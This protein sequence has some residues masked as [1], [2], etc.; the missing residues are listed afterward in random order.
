MI[1]AVA[2]LSQA[3][4]LQLVVS[5]VVVSGL[6]QRVVAK[7]TQ[8][9]YARLLCVLP[10]AVGHFCIP[11]LFNP[12]TEFLVLGLLFLLQGW[13]ATFKVG[14]LLCANAHRVWLPKHC[15]VHQ[16]SVQVLLQQ[17]LPV[18]VLGHVLSELA[19]SLL[20]VTGRAVTGP[21]AVSYPQPLQCI[22]PRHWAC[23][24]LGWASAEGP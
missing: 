16:A 3:Q 21:V 6:L 10:L 13:L 12:V 18:H 8:P 5:Y 9:G 22:S 2:G 23:R 19:A 15:A 20:Q 1:Q 14:S 7:R 11:A 17:H 4:K 24:S